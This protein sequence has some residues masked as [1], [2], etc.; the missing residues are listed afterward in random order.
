MGGCGTAAEQRFDWNALLRRWLA[1]TAV[2]PEQPAQPTEPEQPAQPEAPEPARPVQPETPSADVDASIRASE[3]EVV[4]LVNAERAKYGLAALA[5]EENLSALARRKSRMLVA[6]LAVTVGATI[7]AGLVTVYYD[8]PRQMGEQFLA[9]GG[10][11]RHSKDGERQRLRA[12]GSL[13]RSGRREAEARE[14][15]FPSR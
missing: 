10:H 7:L 9:Y 13:R 6:L 5:E 8:M 15:P 12:P 2:R 11:R 3:R 1:Q 14:Q 4:R